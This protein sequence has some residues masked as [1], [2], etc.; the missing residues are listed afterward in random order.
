MPAAHAARTMA[1]ISE[2]NP[3]QD[4][5]A[6]LTPIASTDGRLVKTSFDADISERISNG[7][8]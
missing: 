6:M 4:A 2:L 8:V 7:N 1:R 3:G 5:P